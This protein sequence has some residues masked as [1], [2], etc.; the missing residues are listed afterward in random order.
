MNMKTESNKDPFEQEIRRIS[1]EFELDI[2]RIVK[3]RSMITSLR[4]VVD[5]ESVMVREKT[6]ELV[7]ILNGLRGDLDKVSGGVSYLAD[8]GSDSI[9][10]EDIISNIDHHKSSI[11]RISNEIEMNSG[12]NISRLESLFDTYSSELLAYKDILDTRIKDLYEDIRRNRPKEAQTESTAHG[13]QNNKTEE[14]T[15]KVQRDS[16][17][18]FISGADSNNK[19]QGNSFLQVIPRRFLVATALIIA[20]LSLYSYQSFYNGTEGQTDSTDNIVTTRNGDTVKDTSDSAEPLSENIDISKG[21]GSEAGPKEPNEISS[22]DPGLGQGAYRE[23]ETYILRVRG[24]NIRSG[25]GRGYEIVTVV[26]SGDILEKSPG[27]TERWMKVKTE[28]GLEGWI[29]KSLTQKVE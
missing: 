3:I 19:K 27:E 13:R 4:E 21:E 2:L 20:A 28:D 26:R 18:P 22:E 5:D 9:D 15:D 29:A 17:L 23:K 12:K 8:R 1:A 14:R 10:T 11:I 7:S 6:S 25:P 16:G 24:A